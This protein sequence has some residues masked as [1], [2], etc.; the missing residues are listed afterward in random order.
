M[1]FAKIASEQTTSSNYFFSGVNYN[2]IYTF[3]T[4]LYLKQI[5]KAKPLKPLELC[6]L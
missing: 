5:T 4:L 6:Q 3:F 1:R 2:S